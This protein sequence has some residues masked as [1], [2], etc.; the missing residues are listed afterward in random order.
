M[1]QAEEHIRELLKS[2]VATR[3]LAAQRLI[4]SIDD[5]PEDPE[6]EMMRAA[7]LTR[8]ARADVDGTAKRVDAEEVRR[9]VAQRLLEAQKR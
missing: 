5:D 9:L 3:A 4:E 7:E 8:R 2:P 6:A 1:A